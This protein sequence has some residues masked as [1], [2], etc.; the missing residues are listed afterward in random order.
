MFVISV[1][2]A[3]IDMVSV[4]SGMPSQI[5]GN[6][7]GIILVPLASFVIG[8]IPLLGGLGLI[9][10]LCL[11]IASLQQPSSLPGFLCLLAG[12]I[13]GISCRKSIRGATGI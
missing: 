12:I 7:S 1:V 9:V 10:F 3:L 2:L 8:F 4:K 5:S 11:S 6:L 13:S